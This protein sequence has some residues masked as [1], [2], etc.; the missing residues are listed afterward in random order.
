MGKYKKYL[1]LILLAGVLFATSALAHSWYPP[2]CCEYL[3]HCRPVACDTITPGD[4]GSYL[5]EGLKFTKDMV[6]VAPDGKCH[7]CINSTD[8]GKVP[9][10]IYPFL[11]Y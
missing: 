5:Y 2:E 10:C 9:L 7:V 3:Q 11:G 1:M 8:M 4:H 6:H